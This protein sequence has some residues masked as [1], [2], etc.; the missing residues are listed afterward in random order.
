MVLKVGTLFSGIGA[1]E[2]AIKNLKM[3]HSIEYA[4]D[5]NK[6]AMETYRVNH[7]AKHYYD[8]VCDMTETNYD[9]DLLIYGFPCQPF[10]I[11]GLR[12]GSKDKRGMLIFS[13]VKILNNHLPRFFIAENVPGL[14]QHHKKDM[15]AILSAMRVNYDVQYSILNSLDFGV[16]QRRK[17]LWFVGIRKDLKTNFDFT[18]LHH[19]KR[20]SLRN[21]LER[22]DDKKYYAR[23]T[24]LEKN[25][26]KH[27]LETSRGDII[28]CITH[29]IA[30]DGSS[31][32]YMSYVAAVYNAIGEMRKPTPEE[33]LRLFGF[34]KTFK[35]PP[36]L[37]DTKKY[38][39]V[40]NTMVV[41]CLEGIMEELIS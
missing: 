38:E 29:T 22:M 9:I 5:N 41:P 8:D 30:R 20:P 23:S 28:P 35:F 36:D 13:A 10:S 1:P 26:F 15:E 16:P 21:L 18:K 14:L 2:V 7:S 37:C 17:R 33:C 25:K 39:Q 3:N 27:I 34:P 32:E 4:C 12:N 31:R 11:A 24:L 19:R 6:Y 40:G